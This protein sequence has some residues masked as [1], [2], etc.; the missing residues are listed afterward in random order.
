MTA[1][2]T[3]V[4]ATDRA[5][6]SDIAAA[7]RRDALTLSRALDARLGDLLAVRISG[8][9]RSKHVVEGIAL[10]ALLVLLWLFVGFYRSMTQGVR[11]A[12]LRPRR[13]RVR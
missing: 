1:A 8:L 6:A 3:K 9:Q 13:G 2:L 5:P 4:S 11:R 7:S 10:L 12:D